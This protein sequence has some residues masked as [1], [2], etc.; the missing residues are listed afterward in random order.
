[1][2]KEKWKII[3]Y[4]L[5]P[6]TTFYL[7]YFLLRFLNNM[8]AFE[9]NRMTLFAILRIV[10]YVVIG[11][12]YAVQVRMHFKKYRKIQILINLVY[13]ALGIFVFVKHFLIMATSTRIFLRNNDVFIFMWF[14][15]LLYTT[16]F[17][18]RKIS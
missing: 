2:K 15:I 6:V 12:I 7:Q 10:I 1:M 14:G 17:N 11:M 4:G 9:P 8:I 13:M 3:I 5:L 18:Q 16:L